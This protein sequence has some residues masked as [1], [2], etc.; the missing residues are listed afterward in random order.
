MKRHLAIQ[1]IS[2]LSCFFSCFVS[3]NLICNH[4]KNYSEPKKQQKIIRLILLVPIY[5]IQSWLSL[6]F[7]ENS[8]FFTLVRCCYESIV[9]HT[10]LSLLLV[11]L[12]GTVRFT[13]MMAKKTVTHPFP[14][15]RMV[16]HVNEGFLLQMFRGTLQFVILIPV[17]S[18]VALL[19][20][21]CGLYH[22]GDLSLRY[23]YFWIELIYNFSVSLSLYCLVLFYKATNRELS[24]NPKS[25][26][27]LRFLTVKSVI[28]FAYWQSLGIT[29]LIQTGIIQDV[30]SWTVSHIKTV[31]QEF[32]MSIEMAYAALA[33]CVSFDYKEFQKDKKISF[34]QAAYHAFKA[35][36][37]V[38]E[39]QLAIVSY[40][41]KKKKKK[42]ELA[43]GSPHTP[44][45]FQ[46]KYV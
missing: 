8:L 12:G 44:K 18:I 27:L 42:N 41:P 31:I 15:N 23:G 37:L 16:S 32:M 29:V 45:N 1:I 46:I 10:F 35:K 38:R 34:C 19:L 4:L 21:A 26:T 7:P 9:L 3:I 11:Y 30:G 24:K 6:T 36:D 5:S 22:E 33:C 25:N 13:K 28:F 20:N 17:C 2:G 14:M 39:L 43:Y 40:L